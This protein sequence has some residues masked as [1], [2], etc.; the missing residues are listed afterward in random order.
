M[1]CPANRSRCGV[2]SQR[3]PWTPKSPK[4]WSSVTTRMTLGGRPAAACE[5]K[6]EAIRKITATVFRITMLFGAK[7]D[8][9]YP[10]VQPIPN[11]TQ[12]FMRGLLNAAGRA[13]AWQKRPRAPFEFG[14]SKLAGSG[15]HLDTQPPETRRRS[16]H[17]GGLG[18]QRNPF[19]LALLQDLSALGG[20]FIGRGRAVFGQQ[21]G[22]RNAQ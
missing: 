9:S 10:P 16:Q 20:V 6:V 5:K 13:G 21:I 17:V 1:L 4:P 15:S 19:D 14:R 2:R 7:G 12:P 8:N 22:G 11:N 3:L 18:H